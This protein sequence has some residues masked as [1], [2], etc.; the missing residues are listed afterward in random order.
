[1]IT[2]VK[3][4]E[5]YMLQRMFSRYFL[6]LK[7]STPSFFFTADQVQIAIAFDVENYLGIWLTIQNLFCSLICISAT[8]DQFDVKD[9]ATQRKLAC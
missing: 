7:I 2:F 9:E 3:L 4:V 8:N 5:S 6:D 1:M